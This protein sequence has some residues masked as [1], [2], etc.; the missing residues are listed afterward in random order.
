MFLSRLICNRRNLT[1]GFNVHECPN[2]INTVW[3][4]LLVIGTT[5]IIYTIWAGTDDCQYLVCYCNVS[6]ICNWSWYHGFVYMIYVD[7]KEE[8]RIW[9]WCK[10]YQRLNIRI[11]FVLD[12]TTYHIHISW[13]FNQKN[14][15][16][17]NLSIFLYWETICIFYIRQFW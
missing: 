7:R 4:F 11:I 1:N 15:G 9:N 13:A 10:L 16:N 3:K 12:L 14:I 8:N 17:L 2:R 5:T 6:Y